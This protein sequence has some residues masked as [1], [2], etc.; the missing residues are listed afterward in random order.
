MVSTR[1]AAVTEPSADGAAGSITG[2]LKRLGN[3]TGDLVRAEVA[4]AKLEFRELARQA[5]V[6]GAKVGAA[7]ALAMV[8]VLALAAAAVLALGDALADRYGLAALIV[9]IVLLLVG[10]ALAWSGIRSMARN[11]GP[12]ATIATLRQDGRWAARELRDLKQQL[13]EGKPAPERQALGK[14]GTGT[15]T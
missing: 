15:R 11:Q 4:L 6:D 1:P 5:A 8:G 14:T 9:G 12:A 13:G 7:A 2:L 3:E 10:G